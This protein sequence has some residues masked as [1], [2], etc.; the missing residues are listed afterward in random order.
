MEEQQQHGQPTEEEEILKKVME[1]SL[2]THVEEE[3][4]LCPGLHDVLLLST[5]EVHNP[6]PP[7]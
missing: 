4:P 1:D 7:P 2:C 3:R 6:P 5:E